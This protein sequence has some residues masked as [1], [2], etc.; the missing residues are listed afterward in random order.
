MNVNLS[1]GAYDVAKKLALVWLPAAGAL[2]F[3]LAKI[4]G[5]PN[6]EDVVGSITVIDTF[7]GV[8]LGISNT[9]YNNSDRPFDGEVVVKDVP[10][11]DGTTKKI[12]SLQFPDEPDKDLLAAQDKITF[13][14]VSSNQDFWNGSH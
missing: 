5:L 10:M 4:W 2:Y 9:S 11:E 13:K 12:F 14:V 1:N 3:S 7:L 8:V 6:P